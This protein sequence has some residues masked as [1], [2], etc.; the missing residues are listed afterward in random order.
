MASMMRGWYSSNYV[1]HYIDV[2][3][4][5]PNVAVVS[6]C[7]CALHEQGEKLNAPKQ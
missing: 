1:L 2:F 4:S 3:L 5:T 6:R 7:K